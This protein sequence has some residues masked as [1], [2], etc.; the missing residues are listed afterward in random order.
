MFK[1][2]VKVLIKCMSDHSYTFSPKDFNIKIYKKVNIDV[3]D[4][5][6]TITLILF[7][8]YNHYSVGS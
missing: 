5:L 6:F 8:I 3:A 4:F 7:F 2:P 1:L